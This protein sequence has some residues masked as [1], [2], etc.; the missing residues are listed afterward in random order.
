M[1]AKKSTVLRSVFVIIRII[2]GSAI[3]A[4]GIQWFFRPVS[5]VSGGITGISM[6]VN[7]LTGFPTGI[8]MIILNIPIFIIAFRRFGYKFLLTSMVAM[9]TSSTTIDLLSIWN[10]GVTDDPF[11]G[12]IFGGLV[13]G[14]GLGL[15]YA[16]GSTTGGMDVVSKIIRAKRPYINF[17]TFILITDAVVIAAYAVIF[18]RFDNAMYTVIAVYIYSRI[19]DLMLY[20]TSQ[21][22]L[23][24][25]ISERSDDIKQEIVK[26]LKRGVTVVNARGAYSGMDKQ[27]LFCVVKRQQI[28]QI[29]RIVKDIDTSAFVIVSDT[30]DVFGNG[31]ENI[32]VE[33]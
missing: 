1:A 27:I 3:Y 28:V 33:K 10:F 4:V 5:M 20:G 9:L 29:R 2:L 14:V 25:I 18:R 31:F 21:C 26:T 7:M 6:I 11:L 19:I 13:C 23:C 22:K 16:T 8:L 12:A 30:R 15:I 32:N 17:G 24:Q